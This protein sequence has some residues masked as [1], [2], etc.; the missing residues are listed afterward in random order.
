MAKFKAAASSISGYLDWLVTIGLAATVSALGL[1]QNASAQTVSSATLLV[2]GA[3]AIASIRDRATARMLKK[4]IESLPASVQFAL[5]DSKLLDD[6][7]KTGL[8]RIFPQTVN[9][10]WIPAIGS[11]RQVSIAKLKLNFT[12]DPEYFFAFEEVLARGG[13]VS[14]VLSDPRSPAMWLRYL[15]EPRGKTDQVASETAWILGLEELAV[16]ISRLNNWRKRMLHE[17][18][19]AQQLYVGLFP[20]YPTHAFYR[21]DDD[22]YV[23]HYPYMARGFHAP[24]FLFNDPTTQTHSFLLRCN[25]SVIDAS[26]ELNDEV[27]AD[28]SARHGSGALS[29]LI[30]DKSE[31]RVGRKRRSNSS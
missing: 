22:L 27:A 25:A 16:E 26:I 6:S 2:L 23:F 31:V 30:V 8:S 4:G 21:F 3:F 24:A 29:D 9:H 5:A 13:S 11:A 7:Q 15:E 20:H 10:N 18:V 12:E 19:D 17:G 28:V 14:I 1:Q